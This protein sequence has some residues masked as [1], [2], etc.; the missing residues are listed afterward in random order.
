ML[1]LT[2]FGHVKR[3]G[4]DDWVNGCAELEVDSKRPP[5][6][7]PKST[8]K[9]VVTDDMKRMHLSPSDVLMYRTGRIGKG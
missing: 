2:W 6:G 9:D 5:R 1:R 3:K 4:D 8:C 7:R